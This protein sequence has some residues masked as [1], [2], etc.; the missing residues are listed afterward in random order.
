MGQLIEINDTLKL[1]LGSNKPDHFKADKI[2]PFEVKGKRMYNL[3]PTRVFLV[4]EVHGKWNYV[5]HAKILSQTIDAEKDITYGKFKVTK[6]Y[7][8]EYKLLVNKNEPPEGKSYA[9]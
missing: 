6:I 7:T 4:E 2:Y 9:K 3:Y 5:G 8:E 1:K